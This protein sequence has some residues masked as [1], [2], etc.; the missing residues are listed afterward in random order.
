MFVVSAVEG[1]EVQT[2]YA[3]RIAEQLGVPRMIFINKLDKERASFE[4][5]LTELRE[6]F[7]AGI[8]PIELPI[9]KEAAF[10]GVADLFRDKPYV[11]DSG[12]A[13][14]VAMPDEMADR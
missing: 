3:W 10:H 13:E 7:G 11:Y 4:R 14:V 12:K 9:G 1:V 5:T 6:R 8:A 2:V